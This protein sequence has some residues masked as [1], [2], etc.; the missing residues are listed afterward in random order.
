[1]GSLTG[2][3]TCIK[4]DLNIKPLPLGSCLIYSGLNLD[5]SSPYVDLLS[6][7][8]KTYYYSLHVGKVLHQKIMEFIMTLAIELKETG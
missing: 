8:K 1:M 4:F 2:Q 5:C 6:N 7:P 3:C